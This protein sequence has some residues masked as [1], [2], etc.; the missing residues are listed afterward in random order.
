MNRDQ[1]I[2]TL[3]GSPLKFNNTSQRSQHGFNYNRPKIPRKA[4]HNRSFVMVETTTYTAPTDV[5]ER[6]FKQQRE[7]LNL[8]V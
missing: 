4:F 5:N 6:G 7:P 8:N 2:F 1:S 3:S